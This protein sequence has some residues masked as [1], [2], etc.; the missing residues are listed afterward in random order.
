[1]FIQLIICRNLRPALGD[2]TL[3]SVN[4]PTEV[5]DLKRQKIMGTNDTGTVMKGFVQEN[6]DCDR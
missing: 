5:G 6:R 1:M 4:I 2:V 3:K